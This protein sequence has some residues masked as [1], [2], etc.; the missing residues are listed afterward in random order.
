VSVVEAPHSAFAYE[1]QTIDGQ[2]FQGTLQAAS[3]EEVQS[4]LAALQLRVLAVAP[5]PPEKRAGAE[6][7]ADE[8]LIFNQ[9]LAHLADAG[10]PVERGLRLI[11]ID[12]RSGKLA[13]A[14][15]DVAAELERGAPLQTAFA[16]HA[17]QFPP[18]Y[19]RLVEA[20]A[21]AGNLPG[22]LFS[23]GR[24]L[25]LVGRLKRSLWRTLAYPLMVFAA[26]SLVLLFISVFVIPHFENIYIGFRTTLPLLTIWMLAAARVYPWI[27][28]LGWSLVIL[29]LAIDA[30]ARAANT[31]G[32]PWIAL[33]AHVPFLGVILRA[34]LLARWIDALRLGIEAGL[35]LP[36]A[37]ALAAAASGDTP[38]EHDANL[39]AQRLGQGLPL[40]DFHTRRIPE[41]VTAAIELATAAGSGSDLSSVLYS[42][43]RMYEQQAEQ[44]L[45]LMPSILT[46]ILLILIAIS[47]SLTIGSMLLPLVN[48]IK[49]VSGGD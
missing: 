44:R 46:P 34:N 15:R 48:L 39:L 23:L 35:D 36:R 18:L 21:S 41:T 16:R 17:A 2:R 43:S 40:S 25:E 13:R 11:A 28:A 32:M 1:A 14:A 38:L 20:G 24:H 9:Q 19:G 7:G 4:R 12:L 42:L 22:M 31:R 8:F 33:L 37:L 45:R 47:V 27:F 5:A 26:L 30:V 6:L 29:T 49:S 10:L 3:A